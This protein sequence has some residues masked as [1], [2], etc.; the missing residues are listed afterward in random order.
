MKA[1]TYTLFALGVL[2]TV[3]YLSYLSPQFDKQ[4]LIKKDQEETLD[5]RTKTEKKRKAEH[6]VLTKKLEEQI[7]FS[8][9][10]QRSIDTLN[11][12]IVA[13]NKEIKKQTTL[14]KDHIIDLAEDT[15][16]FENDHDELMNELRNEFGSFSVSSVPGQ[17]QRKRHITSDCRS[18]RHYP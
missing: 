11:A 7:A 9:S 18:S 12:D 17:L 1:L 13:L 15:V 3:G 8:A 14:K 10:T 5:Q 4:T 6:A 2:G 16:A